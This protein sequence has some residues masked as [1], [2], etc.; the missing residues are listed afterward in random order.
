MARLVHSKS[1]AK[2]IKNLAAFFLNGNYLNPKGKSSNEIIQHYSKI[3][4]IEAWTVK[5]LLIYSYGR[6]DVLAVE[7]LGVRKGIQ[8][9]YETSQVPTISEAKRLTINWK[10]L[11]TIGTLLSWKVL[12]D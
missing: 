8:I 5:M 11:A 3:K 9:M 6:L 12:P 7:D 2:Y 4:G 10:D 1:K